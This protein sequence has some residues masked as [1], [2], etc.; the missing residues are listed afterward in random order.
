MPAH[1]RAVFPEML[2]AQTAWWRRLGISIPEAKL[3]LEFH[4]AFASS[5]TRSLSLRL[6]RQ[7]AT[8]IAVIALAVLIAAP[9]TAAPPEEDDWTFHALL[10]LGSAPL[11][12]MPSGKGLSLMAT[13]ECPLLE[14]WKRVVRNHH[15]VLLDAAGTPMRQFPDHVSFRV[16][17]S[18][19]SDRLLPFDKPE[20]IQGGDPKTWLKQLSFRLKI[21]HGL[22]AHE[23]DP[24]G[25][26]NL[27]V[28]ADVPYDE[29]IYLVSFGIKDI[30]ATD[31]LMLEVFA[32][33]GTRVGRFHLELL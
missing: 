15:T 9:L 33:D 6:P 3:L 29:R 1:L 5:Q 12:L 10:P 7:F 27:G 4:A 8:R 11:S 19:R 20:P 18:T 23:I 32:P 31:R 21:F 14:G 17:A 16:T 22:E 13:A 30:P 28:P 24:A 25:V 2:P 26:T